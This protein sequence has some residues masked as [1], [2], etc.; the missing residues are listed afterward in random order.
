MRQTYKLCDIIYEN[1]D[2]CLVF[3]HTNR[4][5]VN[6]KNRLIKMK[7]NNV[8]KICHTYQSFFYDDLKDKIVFVDKYTMTPNRYI[9]L[10]YQAFTKHNI[11]IIMSGDINQCEPINDDKTIPQN[12]FTSKA[13][14]EMCPQ[15]IE[16]TYIEESARYDDKTRILLNNFLKYKHIFGHKF[17]PNGNYYKN[18]CW[19]ND[20]RRRVTEICC[21]RH[22][23]KKKSYEINFKYKS[24][25]EKCEVCENMPV[26]ATD[27]MKKYNMFNM[28]E[29]EI[30]RIYKNDNRQLEFEIN[31]ET[32]DYYEFREKFLPNFCNTVYKF[33]GGQIDDHYNIYDTHEMD[34]KEMYTALSRTTKL[35]YIHL[36]NNQ[37]CKRYSERK[38]QK[39]RDQKFILK[40]RFS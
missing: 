32:F 6:I 38:R 1:K 36:R 22:V 19:L 31:N 5:V 34:V 26:I 15:R 25:V 17:Q 29:Y 16:L 9:T 14:E 2:N 10:L 37:L 18:I 3:S 30:D 27:N 12:Y 33:Q 35:E 40:Y 39:F 7:V 24:R 8:N 23:E 28:M 21:N 13:V 20:T 4:A 11:T